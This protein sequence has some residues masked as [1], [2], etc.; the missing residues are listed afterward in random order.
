MVLSVLPCGGLASKGVK[1]RFIDCLYFSVVIFLKLGVWGLVS[2][3]CLLCLPPFPG[4]IATGRGYFCAQWLL[5]AGSGEEKTSSGLEWPQPLLGCCWSEEKL[6]AVRA[7]NCAQIGVKSGLCSLL[8]QVCEEAGALVEGPGA[9]WGK[10]QA[11]HLHLFS[12]LW[13]LGLHSVLD[14]QGLCVLLFYMK[15]V[16][17]NVPRHPE[18]FP[19]QCSTGQGWGGCC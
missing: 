13:V 12:S 10:Q 19:G 17:R 1:M 16:P 5:C 9:R 3:S 4:G 18:I 15:A 14:F 11:Q 2:G 6:S 8:C 7:P